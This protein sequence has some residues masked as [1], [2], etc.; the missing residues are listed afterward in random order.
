MAIW[1]QTSWDLFCLPCELSLGSR[2]IGADD[3]NRITPGDPGDLTGD[4]FICRLVGLSGALRSWSIPLELSGL[5][6]PELILVLYTHCGCRTI[7]EFVLMQEAQTL[8]IFFVLCS[9]DIFTQMVAGWRSGWCVTSSASLLTT[10]RQDIPGLLC[11]VVGIW[12]CFSVLCS[13][14]N[15]QAESAH[16]PTCLR[17]WNRGTPNPRDTLEF[18]QETPMRKNMRQLHGKATWATFNWFTTSFNVQNG[19]E[20]AMKKYTHYATIVA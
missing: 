18:H 1:K 15:S 5:E 13:H 20:C 8:Q 14:R 9:P 6:I 17:N 3:S 7:T 12:T 10:S 2:I 16:Q 11:S 19:P 4:C